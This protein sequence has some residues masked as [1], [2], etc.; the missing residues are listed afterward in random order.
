MQ[1]NTQN[2]TLVNKNVLV[3]SEPC[4]NKGFMLLSAIFL[5]NG[6]HF[7]KNE[8]DHILFQIKDN[9]YDYF[10][11]SIVKDRIMVSIPVNS[12]V[13]YKTQFTTYYD[14]SEYLEA[15]LF[16]YINNNKVKGSELK[17]GLKGDTELENIDLNASESE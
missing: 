4:K 6:W 10:E 1:T 11:I 12:R 7:V 17:E 16:D 13:Q 5:E 3:E 8:L 14:A 2:N 15:R 9:S